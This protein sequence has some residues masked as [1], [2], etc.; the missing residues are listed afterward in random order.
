ADLGGRPYR[1]TAQFADVLD[2]VPQATVRLNDV[3]VG[4]VDQISL[5]PD[6]SVALVSL[7][8][9]G[10]VAL[11]AT[12]HAE[13]SSASLLG[14]KFVELVAPPGQPAVGPLRDGAVIPVANTR[15]Y[16]EVEEVFGALSLLLNGGGLAQ[17]QDIVREVN[18]TTSGNEP[19][20]RD[21]LTQVARLTG[22]LDAQRATIVRAIDGLDRL[23]GVLAGQTGHIDTALDQLGP[24]LRVL[25]DQ[26]DQ[27]VTMLKSLDRLS[28]VAVDTVN[29]SR[30]DLVA[31]LRALTP[32][33]RELAEAGDNIPKSLQILLTYPFPDY[34]MK[35]LKGDYFNTDLLFKLDVN[36]TLGNLLRSSQPPVAIP[37]TP[38]EPLPG[39]LGQ[40]IRTPLLPEPRPP[41]G[42]GGLLLPLSG[43]GGGGDR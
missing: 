12:T 37:G 43:G 30:D 41:A 11:P 25:N 27:L 1:V 22:Q 38:G 8:I 5:A 23:A 39:A 31:D 19:Q 24:G 42:L 15:R 4:R 17:L 6:G 33:L 35:A 10:D 7:A 29:R 13:L 21:L 40:I 20:L 26:R 28:G 2:L 36:S 32:T 9:N 3:A 16:P 34:A 14:E 18:A